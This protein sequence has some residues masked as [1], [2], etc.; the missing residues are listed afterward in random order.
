MN[1]LD[2]IKERNAEQVKLVDMINSIEIKCKGKQCLV[3]VINAL[4][5]KLYETDRQKAFG[6][7]KCL[8]DE[9]VKPG[10]FYDIIMEAKVA[11]DGNIQ[12]FIDLV[13]IYGSM[14]P[15]HGHRD[16]QLP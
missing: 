11:L 16:T 8:F 2:I 4:F 13:V 14:V 6:C 12:N 15:N 5:S 9:F 10:P 1:A 7:I 3:T